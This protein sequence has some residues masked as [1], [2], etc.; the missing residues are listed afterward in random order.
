MAGCTMEP[1]FQMYFL[2]N[3]GDNPACYVSLPEGRFSIHLW[4]LI[5]GAGT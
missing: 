2:L 3:I 4:K 5:A 1:E